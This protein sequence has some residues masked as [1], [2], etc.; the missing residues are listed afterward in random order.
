MLKANNGSITRSNLLLRDWDRAPIYSFAVSLRR[1][2]HVQC[3]DKAG[4]V[5][6]E[7]CLNATN[8]Q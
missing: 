1:I 6:P 4:T 3:A 2:I 8:L 5:L 7:D